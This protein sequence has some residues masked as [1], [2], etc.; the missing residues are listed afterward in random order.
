MTLTVGTFPVTDIVWGSK[1]RWVDG[2]VEVDKGELLALAGEDVSV[3]WA[4]IQVA[5]PGASARIICVRDIIEPKIKAEGPG[6]T[7]PGIAGRPMATAGR[8]RTHRLGGMTI[9]VS[10]GIPERNPD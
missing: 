4:D 7:Y 10:G 2:T 5:R 3:G 1:T 8:G 6:T 9:T